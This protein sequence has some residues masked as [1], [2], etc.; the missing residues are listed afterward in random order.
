MRCASTVFAVAVS[1]LA[2]VL[3]NPP[4]QAAVFGFSFGPAGGQ[5]ADGTFTTGIAS[6]TE[7]WL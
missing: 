5:F 4:A 7:F 3:A 6:P 1:Y 2:G